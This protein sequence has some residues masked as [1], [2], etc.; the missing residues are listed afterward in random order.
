MK[1]RK[2]EESQK[3]RRRPESQKKA[4]KPEEGQK[5][6]RITLSPRIWLRTEKFEG[7]EQNNPHRE[8]FISIIEK[9]LCQRNRERSN[10]D[11]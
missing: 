4:R 1:A 2:P 3:A 9:Q 10:L 8:R 11:R 6:R 7:C 5:A